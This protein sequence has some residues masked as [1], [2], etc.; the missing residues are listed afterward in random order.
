MGLESGVSRH[1]DIESDR[2]EEPLLDKSDYAVRRGYQN[3][4][5]SVVSVPSSQDG[6]TVF[7]YNVGVRPFQ[8]IS[9]A[10]IFLLLILVSVAFGIYGVVHANPDYQWIEGAK[11]KPGKG[12]SIPTDLRSEPMSNSDARWQIAY[13][14]MPQVLKKALFQEGAPSNTP[15]WITLGLTLALSGPFALGVLYL[16]RERTKELVYA[17]LPFI[18]L[19][20]IALN[21]TWFI[22]CQRSTE[23]KAQF[24]PKG[25][26]TLFGIILLMCILM[27]YV[28]Y[29]SW[30][31]IQ[32]TIRVVKTSSQALYQNL[33]LIF[34]LPSL[35]LALVVF[36]VP[37]VTFMGFAYT[38]G[39]L[40]PNP[41]M[42]EHPTRQCGG[43][44]TPCCVWEPAAWVPY[45]N[46]LSG[47]AL[48]WSA[49]I[50][51][52][53]QVFTISGTIA[54]WYFAQA[55]SSSAN[56]TKRALSVAFGPSFGTACFAGLVVAIVRV[57]RG[58]VNKADNEQAQESA[59]AI[60]VRACLQW[61]LDAVEFF[62]RFTSN[63]AAI[64]GDSFCASASMTYDLLRRNM[65]STVLVEVISDRL[66][67][68]VTFVLTVAYALLVYGVLS[69]STSLAKDQRLIVSALSWLILFLVLVLFVRVLSNIIDTVY[70]CYAMDKDH[71]VASKPEVHDVLV[72]L[73]ASREDNPSLA[74]R[75]E[76]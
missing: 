44:D 45:Y 72:L 33:A 21:L 48:L 60:F 73:P 34:I 12:C 38:N 67:S 59:L 8:D 28:I 68:M 30:D 25:Q 39:K 16:L 6:S 35:S 23:C 70:I 15:I 14:I 64:T 31:R 74:V 7:G 69:L 55:G 76:Y 32:L 37:I 58:A 10:I 53:I 2:I 13:V 54:Q 36:C 46:Y 24:D 18:V 1:E 27:I 9:F 56:A 3:Q 49:M 52:Q 11:Y 57:I 20:P 51:A 75:R 41:D 22:L 43:A 71:G 62:T 17:T 26:I 50:I 65:L 47:F 19:L 42:I 4:P 40:V 63:F 29:T 5:D 66:L 61:I